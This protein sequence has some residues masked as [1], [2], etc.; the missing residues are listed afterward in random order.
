MNSAVLQ[1]GTVIRR[2]KCVIG[3]CRAAVCTRV[4]WSPNL[5][6]RAVSDDVPPSSAPQAAGFVGPRPCLVLLFSRFVRPA[7]DRAPMYQIKGSRSVPPNKDKERQR[8]RAS[9]PVAVRHHTKSR[10]HVV[11]YL[12]PRPRRFLSRRYSFPGMR[13]SASKTCES[14]SACHPQGVKAGQTR[15]FSSRPTTMV[16]SCPLV[17]RF[18]V[19]G[20]SK[21]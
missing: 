10:M 16:P 2:G 17:R 5:I 21:T 12:Q 1:C 7:R 11:C 13:A 20:I 6:V 8:G 9:T 4:M 14:G 19:Q 3:Q 18:D 15:S